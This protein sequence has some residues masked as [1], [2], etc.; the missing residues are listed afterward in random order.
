MP[1]EGRCNLTYHCPLA[2]YDVRTCHPF[3]MLSL[4]TVPA[5][6]SLYAEMLKGD[7]YRR[8]KDEMGIDDREQVKDDFQRVVN[9]GHKTPDWMAKQYVFQF[10]HAHFPHFAEQVLFARNDLARHLQNYEAALMV[11]KLGRYCL[12]K[13][14]FW[15]PMHDG[16][17]SSLHTGQAIAAQASNIIE[18]AVGLVPQITCKEIEA[19]FP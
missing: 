14:L 6:R 3:L 1:R 7:I 15:I 17:I 2:E 10:Y 5:E 18:E 4:F 16:Y 12:E 8:I 19:V 9:F 13:S 11:Q